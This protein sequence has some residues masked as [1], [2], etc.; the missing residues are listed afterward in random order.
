VTATK[1]IL[2]VLLLALLLGNASVVAAP[3]ETSASAKPLASST[4]ML[5]V[6]TKDW[7][8]VPG[9]LRRFARADTHSA[10]AKVGADIPIVVGRGGLGWGRGI[11]PFAP[12]PG[13]VK[14]EGDGKSP[15]GV[16]RL[17]SAF[18]VAA[19]DQMKKIKLPYQQLTVDIECVDDTKSAHYNSIVDRSKTPQPDWNSSEKMLAVGDPY[20]LGVVVDHNT[21]PREPGDGSCVFIH[22]WKGN[23]TGT[24]GCTAMASANIDVLVPWLDPAAN[25][26]LVQLPEAQYLKLKSKWRLPPIK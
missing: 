10:W 6:V 20:R 1:L 14:R 4:Q 22:T 2:P 13:P 12:V 11:S 23:G 3:D 25:P 15:A 19:P 8:A 7:G 21:D 17:S 24:S 5:L 18:G 16:F 9:M 26:V